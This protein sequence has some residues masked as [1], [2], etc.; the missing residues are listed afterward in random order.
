MKQSP[1]SNIEEPA[2]NL[3]QINNQLTS[4]PSDEIKHY[5][6]SYN[7]RSIWLHHVLNPQS[8]ANNVVQTIY[9][10]NKIDIQVFREALQAVTNRHAALRTTFAEIEGEPVQLVHSHRP[11]FFQPEDVSA[12]SEEELQNRL[13]EES[14]RLFDLQDGPLFRAFLF[15][16]EPQKH[17]FLFSMHHIITDMWSI[18]IFIK[19]LFHHYNE[20]Q[21]T[22]KK[23]FPPLRHSYQDFVLKQQE[24]LSGSEARR[25]QTFWE[26]Q[27]Q[28]ELPL[29]NL[30]TDKP[31]QKSLA[32]Q[33]AVHILTLNEQLSKRLAE[34]ASG[35]K[36]SLLSQ[37][38]AA[39]QIL[40]RRYSGQ[41]DILVG[42]PQANRTAETARLIGYF[43]NPVILRVK[44]EENPPFSRF[45][46]QVH[47]IVED[48]FA[49][50]V[51][52]LQKIMEDGQTT[53]ATSNSPGQ[54][55]FRV[56]FSW[57]KSLRVGDDLMSAGALGV[58]HRGVVDGFDS[59][60][61]PSPAQVSPLDLTL[62]FGEVEQQIVIRF[63]YRTDLFTEATI[64]RMAAHFQAILEQLVTAPETPIANF[65][66]LTAEEKTL[67]A[68]WNS[69]Q[70]TAPPDKTFPEMFAAQ[71]AQ[72]PGAV[73]LRFGD[74]ALTYAALNGRS[75]Q[76]AHYLQS[77]GIQKESIVGIYMETSLEMITA[78]LAVLKAG[79]AFLPL[80]AAFPANRLAFI[81]ADA[82]VDCVLTQK[83]LCHQLPATIAN[84]ICLDTDWDSAVA[85][86]PSAS[87]PHT[88]AQD[89]MAYVIYTSGSTGQPK[90]VGINH[91]GLS[92]LVHEQREFFGIQP[93]ERILQF[94]SLSFDAAVY[95][96]ATAFGAGATLVLIESKDRIP[97]EPLNDFLRKEQINFATLPPSS[98]AV[99]SAQGLPH[100]HTVV[101]AGEACTQELVEQWAVGRRFVNAY[102]P[103][104]ATVCATTTVINPGNQPISI[105][106]P[107]RNF[108]VFVL[109]KWM[110]PVPVGVPG[111]L[112]IGSPFSLARGYLNRPE[113]T[114]EKFI[115]NP[116][117]PHSPSEKLFRTGDLVKYLP[118]GQLLFLGRIDNQ[119]KIRGY[120]IELGE[121]ESVITSHPFVR[122]AVVMTLESELDKKRLVAYFTAEK[123]V[124]TP[125]DLRSY[126]RSLL[127]EY[128]VPATLVR[129]EQFP[130]TTSR[131][132]DRRA[133]AQL[134]TFSQGNAAGKTLPQTP[135]QELV[136]AIWREVLHLEQIGIHDNF[137]ALG[138]HS[139]LATQIVSRIRDAFQIELPI[140][141]L[142]DAPTV[143]ELAAIVAER[144]SSGTA[145]PHLPLVP[146]PVSAHPPLSFSQ[147]RMWFL[148]QLNPQSTAYN[149]PGAL[150]L[151]GPLNAEALAWSLKQL[152]NRH[153]S[154][155]T[156]FVVVD[157][158]PATFIEPDFV[159]DMPL[160]DCRSLPRDERQ[161]YVMHALEE[162]VRTPFQLDK[163][164]LLHVKLF[165]VDDEE[166]ILLV[167]MH[168]IISDQWSMGVLSRD[169]ATFYQA[170]LEN[171]PAK[172]PDMPVQVRDYAVW[173]R[174]LA[175]AGSLEA[176]FTYWAKQ[177]ADLPTVEMPTDRPRPTVQT[178]EG[179]VITAPLPEPVRTGLQQLGKQENATPFMMMLAGFY[180]LINRYTDAKDIPIGTPIA[181][182]RYAQTEP[183]IST[184]VN[185]LVLRTAVSPNLT[186]R[187][188]LQQVKKV[189]LEA[190]AHQDM[191]FE[192]LVDRLQVKRDTSRSPLFQLF[193]NV[194]NA[195]F[196]PPELPGIETE[197]MLVDR[198]AAQ[199]DLSLTVDTELTHQAMLE[200]NTTLFD[201]DRME[202]LF[203]HYWTIMTAAVADPD[204]SIGA[205]PLITQPEIDHLRRL[206]D[207]AV[208]YPHTTCIHQ[209]FETQ[210]EKRAA[211]RA[212]SFAGLSNTYQEL[213]QRANRLARHLQTLGVMR[214]DLV[215]VKLERSLEMIVALLAVHKAGAAYIPLD[216]GF[217]PDRL[218]F[219][220]DDSQARAIIT[221]TQ[222][223]SAAEGHAGL[224]I[225]YVDQLG[226]ALAQLAAHNLPPIATANDLAYMI[227]TSG[228]TGK[229]KGVQVTHRNAVN[230][231]LSMAQ[232]P[233]L[234]PEDTLLSVTTLSFDISVLEIFLP[235]IVGAR[236]ELVSRETA[237][238]PEKLQTALQ[239]SGATIMQAT[240]TTW[241]LLL[242]S[243]WAG[244]PNL[245]I[246][247]G[248]E[249]MPR[250]LAEQLLPRCKELWNMYGPTETTV[251]SSIHRVQ[252]GHSP[253]PVGK[254]IANTTFYI[255]DQQQRPLPIGIPGE[256]YIGGAG[257][258]HGYFNR[259]ELTAE[260]F[261][262]AADVAPLAAI[263]PEAAQTQ[264]LYRTG[265]LARFLPD[266]SVDFLGRLDH[267]VKVRGYRIEL[268]EIE[269]VLA[270]HPALREVVVTTK[271]IAAGDVRLVAYL[272]PGDDLPETAE[273]R[274][275]VGDSLPDYMIPA[276]FVT[277]DA[278]PLT[279]NKKVNRRALPVPEMLTA[280]SA[281]NQTTT[282][283]PL[284]LQLIRIWERVLGVKGIGRHEDFFELGGHSLLA[285]RVFSEIEKIT[286]RKF[287]LSI[288][289]RAPTIAR[290]ADALR[291]EGWHTSWT[292]LVPIQPN[293]TKPVFFYVAPFLISLLSF[294]RLAR[295]LGEDQPLYGLQPQGMD[296]NQPHHTRIE[297][298]AAHYIKEMRTIQPHG[299][300]CLGGH[301]AGSWVAFEMA[302]QLQAAGEEIQL[303]V[304]V[305]SEPPNIIPPQVH[306]LKY[307]I[308]RAMFYWTDKRLWHAI[309]W[310]LQLLYQNLLLLHLGGTE[311][312]RVATIRQAHAHAHRDY[313]S[314]L[315]HG[316]VTFIRS[317][318]SAQLTDK[319]WH[320]QWS[321]L[322]SGELHTVVADCTHAGLVLE[323]GAAELATAIGTAVEEAQSR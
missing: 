304:L 213:N 17:V 135:Q 107:I 187:Q 41:D 155:R 235:L 70:H 28:G 163:L 313:H 262:Q 296:G 244:N 143:A 260:K 169:L 110:Q 226:P 278:F 7:Q 93:G 253:I 315:F 219:M 316:D 207:T 243:G 171:K 160:E 295:H 183:L 139:L 48:A 113:L 251:W 81:F 13:S 144:R 138:G 239:Q 75:N 314:G 309:G 156:R 32:H 62:S 98:L 227:Y 47:Q 255:L 154:L 257:V 60:P 189:A 76:L 306:R 72:T 26:Q 127:P 172:L 181:N 177:L 94:A 176:Q 84:R 320:L 129:I 3:A 254:P 122:E 210:A 282:V 173:Q 222:L 215:G 88:I 274:K 16:Q 289:F 57:Q 279:P 247:C 249:A 204:Q 59:A 74:Q 206:N 115:P 290:L 216:P 180:L 37:L 228:S 117:Y 261:L 162:A 200:F 199:F 203:G 104:E 51:Y 287:P 109:D 53:R 108:Q 134:Q 65:A 270:R 29:L 276:A 195:P 266:G 42:S 286:E 61:Y 15:S 288:L 259:P 161:A 167:N 267:Q 184:L 101:S 2:T 284:E 214:G 319:D 14:Y 230:F 190:Y 80:D 71:A 36:T 64:V 159:L 191:P 9:F 188:F 275:F 194:Q 95:E 293:G 212:Y 318:E 118:D 165:Q 35:H 242:E 151:S 271:E 297:D 131:K 317:K 111:E 140:H 197:V 248:G 68:Q 246:L 236:G 201:W 142:F 323:P 300:Y 100:L 280:V 82:N 192:Q 40:L 185:T 114:A 310:K 298:M 150:R 234:T 102:G 23:K 24:L 125:E 25:L 69:G 182:R 112:Y 265:D 196:S 120:R 238:T 174:R 54:A 44:E 302:Q 34:L 77:L 105:G 27:L 170:Y 225:A 99:T 205:L 322:I 18:A 19:E 85:P 128:M 311:A 292:S 285:I 5:P 283:D 92:N 217:P 263:L 124:P 221:H 277:L 38:F 158:Q 83:H 87:L 229:P 268:G 209:L 218:A 178:Y 291:E 96:L 269:A 179:A 132:I 245:K 33:G 52:P 39:Y 30:P 312:R 175:Q 281:K 86:L 146:Q 10:Q 66:I 43:V 231:L 11:V 78:V 211:Q 20:I 79:A 106:R 123:E 6:L 153:E 45:V 252:K 321:E 89:D 22:A 237:V 303:L 103:T 31:P 148:Y 250:D 21:G 256:L 193:F 166:H 272:I 308:Q 186:F 46:R 137:F 4:N 121:I 233:G 97:G 299:P 202:R 198:G 58:A 116:F 145:K 133:L 90:G 67:L 149:I 305:D 223:F 126:V 119:V 307:L 240:P 56:G 273:L 8:V 136:A 50:G 12:W 241:R 157:G 147:E 232:Q 130:L 258:A 224:Q 220:L 294:A 264:R 1:V 55:L 63:E 91:L 164:P 73:A 301:C 152:F 168:H 49:H 141:T 208:P